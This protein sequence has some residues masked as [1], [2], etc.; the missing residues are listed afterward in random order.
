[1]MRTIVQQCAA[2]IDRRHNTPQNE[3]DYL[4]YGLYGTIP[5]NNYFGIPSF[6][7]SLL[8]LLELHRI[9][10]GFVNIMHHAR[11]IHL[12]ILMSQLH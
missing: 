10:D 3:V 8:F 1:M 7:S 9:N 12:Y 11:G 4:K 2:I 6:N 5:A